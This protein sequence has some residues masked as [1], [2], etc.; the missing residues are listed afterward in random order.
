MSDIFKTKQLGGFDSYK[1]VIDFVPRSVWEINSRTKI[2]KEMF[3][4][5]LEKH[6]CERRRQ[7]KS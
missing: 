5:D 7:E 3:E 1:E 2:I 4:D 6:T